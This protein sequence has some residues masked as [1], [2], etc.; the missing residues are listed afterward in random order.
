MSQFVLLFTIYFFDF[1]KLFTTHLLSHIE[2]GIII[3]C[4][5]TLEAW[6]NQ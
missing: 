1:V 6:L 4:L 2:V 5:S 3:D